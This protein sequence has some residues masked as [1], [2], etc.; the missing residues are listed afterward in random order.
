MSGHP[1]NVETLTDCELIKMS[2]SKLNTLPLVDTDRFHT[3]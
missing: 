1:H 2:M 3:I